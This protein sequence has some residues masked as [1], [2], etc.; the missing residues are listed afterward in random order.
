MKREIVQQY[1]EPT[2]KYQTEN[3]GEIW[4][5]RIPI[6]T[7]GQYEELAAK[8]PKV[9]KNHRVPLD[10]VNEMS[11]TYY[12]FEIEFDQQGY[13]RNWRRVDR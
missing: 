12:E 5:Y 4:A 3:G 9:A 13:I 11:D 2:S 8:D 1:G 6:L 7:K 10:T